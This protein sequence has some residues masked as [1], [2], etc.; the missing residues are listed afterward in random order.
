MRYDSNMGNVAHIVSS[1][2]TTDRY[3]SSERAV[4]PPPPINPLPP[5][6]PLLLLQTAD[7]NELHCDACR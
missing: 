3:C 7:N 6:D 4:W 5:L 1:L 2:V